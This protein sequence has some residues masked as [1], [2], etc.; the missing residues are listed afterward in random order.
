MAQVLHQQR[1][2]DNARKFRV[3]QED[4]DIQDYLTF[5]ER[6]MVVNEV[7]EE[8]WVQQLGPN[9]TGRAGM[10]Y[11]EMDPFVPYHVLKPAILRRYEINPRA[12]RMKL[13][14]MRFRLEDDAT[15]HAS[16]VLTLIRRW[17]IP[18]TTARR[19]R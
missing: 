9:L 19:N 2:G 14:Q 6:H 12:S 16:K 8:E 5:F 7:D 10:V 18:P 17:L 11:A 13:H 1:L 15:A 4:E 3:N